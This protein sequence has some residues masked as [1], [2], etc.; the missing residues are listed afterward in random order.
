LCRNIN[1]FLEAFDKKL[2]KKHVDKQ[3]KQSRVVFRLSA[4]AYPLDILQQILGTVD[5]EI[6][7]SSYRCIITDGTPALDST[8]TANDQTRTVSSGYK[9]ELELKRPRSRRQQIAGALVP[10]T[11]L[12]DVR[13]PGHIRPVLIYT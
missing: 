3:P 1:A 12:N 11:N 4:V 9:F 7:H 13:T 5:K 10:F 8:L 6:L 2:N